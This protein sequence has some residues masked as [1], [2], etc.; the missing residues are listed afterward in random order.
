[1]QMSSI[2]FTV[3][4]VKEARASGRA[5]ATLKEFEMYAPK[6]PHGVDVDPMG[7]YIV[8]GG[9]L[10]TVSPVDS[11]TNTQKALHSWSIQTFARND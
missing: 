4:C 11:F 3:T 9:T 1:M 8:A 2:S 7:E 10:A 5:P 6:S